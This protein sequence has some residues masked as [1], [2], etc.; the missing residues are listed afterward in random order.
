MTMAPCDCWL[1][2]GVVW[3]D[4]LY[5]SDR[6][7]FDILLMLSAS[8][9]TLGFNSPSRGSRWDVEKVGV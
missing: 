5:S 2:A 1:G 3:C 7:V 9:Y 4:L 8:N 6:V